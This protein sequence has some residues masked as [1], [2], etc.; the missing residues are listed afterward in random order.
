CDG[1]QSPQGSYHPGRLDPDA[2]ARQKPVPQAGTHDRAQGP[3]SADGDLAGAQILKGPDP[4][5]V[6]EPGLFR[7]RILWRR[8]SLP[9]LFRQVGARC[10]AFGG[11][12]ACGTSA[13]TI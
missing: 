5:N 13:G 12:A 8:S 2:A 10:L 7:L 3:G 9:A 11:G 6:S 4:R 1:D